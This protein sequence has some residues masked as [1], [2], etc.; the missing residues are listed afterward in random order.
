MDTPTGHLH[1][2]ENF[3]ETGMN[4]QTGTSREMVQHS[5]GLALVKLLSDTN[6]VGVNLEQAAN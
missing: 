2:E 5:C 6:P 4:V 1:T 3:P